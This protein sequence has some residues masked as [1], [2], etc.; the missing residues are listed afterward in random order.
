MSESI[1]VVGSCFICGSEVYADQARERGVENK[2]RHVMCTEKRVQS[3]YEPYETVTR[4]DGTIVREYNRELSTT[5]MIDNA[6]TYH[7]P[8]PDQIHRYTEIRDKAK[9]MARLLAKYVPP[10]REKELALNQLQLTVMMANAGIA[11]GEKPK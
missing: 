2:I 5:T 4:S 8:K 10:G 3:P 7:P 9:E 11:C 1:A 6:F